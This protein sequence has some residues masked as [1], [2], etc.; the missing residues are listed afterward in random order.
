M[1]TL[2][3]QEIEEQLANALPEL[4]PAVEVYAKKEGPPGEDPGAYIFFESMFARYVEVLLA[5]RAGA[6]RD[7]LLGRAFAFVE[8]M[9]RSEDRNIHDLAFIGLYENRD[10]WWYG[11]A[12]PFIG[13]AARAELD[14]FEPR[15][16]EVA[17][18]DCFP[19]PDREII[20]IYGVRDVV[21][22]QLQ[23]EG[24]RVKDVPGITAPR[25]WEPLSDLNQA[26]RAND[27]V[28][29]LSCFGT[30]YPY[31]ICPISGVRCSE[32][33]LLELARDLADIE[34]IE[35]NQR[36]KA[37]VA[38]FHIRL[39]ERVWNM[40]IGGAEHARYDGTLWIADQF[41]KRGLVSAIRAILSNVR[42]QLTNG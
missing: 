41:A 12:L 25:S 7:R 40:R 30:S 39:E 5:M 16:R 20:D 36:E 6:G 2:W 14:Q 21:L 32:A 18:A 19:E 28:A 37:R 8:E 24:Y 11:R 1:V 29:F 42:Q 34:Q 31:V 17:P 10:L 4:R 33:V 9:L 22:C 3:Y 27:A 23:H 13:P 35:P 26:Y 38:F 15:W